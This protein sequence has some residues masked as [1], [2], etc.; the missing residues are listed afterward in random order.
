MRARR[1]KGSRIDTI[2]ATT[3]TAAHKAA[4]AVA[5]STMAQHHAAVAGQSQTRALQAHVARHPTTVLPATTTVGVNPQ[6]PAVPTPADNA[7]V[8]ASVY[9]GPAVNPQGPAPGR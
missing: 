5:R 2:A 4:K 1:A 6:G 3:G 9:Q 8:P 7:S